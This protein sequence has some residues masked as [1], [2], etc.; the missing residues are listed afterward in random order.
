MT[1]AA[2]RHPAPDAPPRDI[3]RFLMASHGLRQHDQQ[4]DGEGSGS[5]VWREGGCV[6][7]MLMCGCE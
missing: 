5:K 7:V 3:L 2:A 4:G 6:F 1:M